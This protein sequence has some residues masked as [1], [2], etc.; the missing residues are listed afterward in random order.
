MFHKQILTPS[1]VSTD[2][3][4]TGKIYL[5]GSIVVPV[6]LYMMQ[7]VNMVFE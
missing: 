6:N 1:G 4:R 2:Y 7:I 5:P 3:C